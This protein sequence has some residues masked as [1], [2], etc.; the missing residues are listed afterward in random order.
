M[1]KEIKVCLDRPENDDFVELWAVISEG[2]DAEYIARHTYY[3]AWFTVS[4]PEGYRELGHLL[5]Y[6]TVVIVCDADGNELFRSSNVDG[7]ARFNTEEQEARRVWNEYAIKTDLT[8]SLVSDG[9]TPAHLFHFITGMF[10]DSLDRW[11]LSYK[12]P[13]IYGSAADDYDENWVGGTVVKEES[14]EVLEKYS[15]LGKEYQIERIHYRHSVCGAEW[16]EY[17][18]AGF[19][20]GVRYPGPYGTMYPKYDAVTRIK[21][22][23]KALFPD[24]KELYYARPYTPYG[25]D[26]TYYTEQKY[27]VSDCAAHL[28]RNGSVYGTFDLHRENVD[29]IE[30]ELKEG[31]SP[32]FATLDDLRKVHPDSIRD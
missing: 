23:L 5:D 21:D 18:A 28:L 25:T 15:Y 6:D 29:R 12:D 30:K 27:S 26:V 9:G 24:S 13:S 2:A 22:A 17:Y 16:D 4:D 20:V 31:T 11:L 10:S 8:S 19:R 14:T 3:G 7:S 1:A 32:F